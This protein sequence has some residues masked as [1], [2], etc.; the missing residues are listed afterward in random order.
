MAEPERVHVFVNREAEVAYGHVVQGAE[1]P[2]DNCRGFSVRAGLAVAWDGRTWTILNPG[3][4][5]I[6]LLGE[7]EALTEL[8]V[9]VFEKL[10]KEGRIHG[11]PAKQE[12]AGR[13]ETAVLA[14]AGEM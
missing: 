3:E 9:S 4:R 8:L 14:A 10:T 5:T 7:D 1:A 13:P 11:L 12:C 6:S 2:T